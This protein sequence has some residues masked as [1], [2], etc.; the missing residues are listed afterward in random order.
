MLERQLLLKKKTQ[1]KKKKRMMKNVF[2]PRLD[3]AVSV[4]QKGRRKWM[5][6]WSSVGGGEKRS[7][8]HTS[9]LQSQR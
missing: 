4:V 6:Q 2:D 5:L 1:R 9:E 3:Q 7:E 8:E